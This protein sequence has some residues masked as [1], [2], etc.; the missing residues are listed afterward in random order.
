MQLE[1]KIVGCLI[2]GKAL[3]GKAENSLYKIRFYY[4]AAKGGGANECRHL[5]S[6]EIRPFFLAERL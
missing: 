6:S 1:F 3:S 2:R 5:S 4:N